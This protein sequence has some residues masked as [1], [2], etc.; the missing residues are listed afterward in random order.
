MNKR[1][2]AR[3]AALQALYQWQMTAQPAHAI[4]GEFIEEER[5][6]K[7]DRELFD[8]ILNGVINRVEEL[9]G[10]LAPHLDRDIAD[11]D[12]VERAVLRLGAFE[13][14][15]SLEVPW[16]VVVNESVELAHAFG[17]EKGHRFVNGVL[18]KV[19]RDLRAME[20]RAR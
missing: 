3:R 6:A 13:L 14:M 5:L 4:T 2:R 7:L 20:M 10:A 9:D 18:D 19:A 11:I 15:C 8:G 1:T 16:R 12:P 17:A